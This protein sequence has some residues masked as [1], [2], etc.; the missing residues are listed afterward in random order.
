MVIK[1]I[2]KDDLES[3]FEDPTPTDQSYNSP[4]MRMAQKRKFNFRN[5]NIQNLKK[6][7]IKDLFIIARIFIF[8]IV[9]GLFLIWVGITSTGSY[10]IPNG[11]FYDMLATLFYVYQFGTVLA[12]IGGILIYDA[13]KRTGY[14]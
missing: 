9:F 3:L 2:V 8:Q 7:N 13:V 11:R 10:Y 4:P 12:I 6:I 1:E 14:L 5:I